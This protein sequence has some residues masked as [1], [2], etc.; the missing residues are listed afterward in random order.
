MT[1]Q[2]TLT[3]TA[4]STPVSAALVSRYHVGSQDCQV[5][6]GCA[7]VFRVCATSCSSHQYSTMDP[8]I[9]ET[10]AEVSACVRRNSRTTSVQQD[11]CESATVNLSRRWNAAQDEVQ[12]I[13]N[14]MPLALTRKRKAGWV[15]SPSVG[16]SWTCQ[17]MRLRLNQ[18]R[19]HRVEQCRILKRIPDLS[20]GGS[21]PEDR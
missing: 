14:D 3:Q 4:R 20:Q 19:Q 15:V 16:K 9:A 5:F 2:R 12:I 18:R 13:D 8:S 11:R 7:F 6:C 17:A 10:M 21:Q 1:R